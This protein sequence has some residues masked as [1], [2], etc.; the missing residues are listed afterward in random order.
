LGEAVFDSCPE[1]KTVIA[2]R[3]LLELFAFQ[4]VVVVVVVG[5]GMMPAM[6]QDGILFRNV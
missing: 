2:K 6:A 3:W 4:C 5:V 1:E